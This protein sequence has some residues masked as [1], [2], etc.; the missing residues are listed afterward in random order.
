VAGAANEKVCAVS[1]RWAQW[2]SWIE[3]F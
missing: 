1:Y 2:L 3:P